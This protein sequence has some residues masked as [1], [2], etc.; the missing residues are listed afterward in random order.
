VKLSL[1]VFRSRDIA[2]ISWEQGDSTTAR[3]IWIF[4]E[5]GALTNKLGEP[6][7]IWTGAGRFAP[8]ID[9]IREIQTRA[10]NRK[11]ITLA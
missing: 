8:R 5:Q 2:K 11:Q 6:A 3:E 10:R 1:G 7:I 4:G 9:G